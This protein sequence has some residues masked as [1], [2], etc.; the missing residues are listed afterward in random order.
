MLQT[1]V[2]YSTNL[3][4]ILDALKDAMRKPRFATTVKVCHN[5]VADWSDSRKQ[6]LS[7]LEGTP[8]LDSLLSLPFEHICQY[9]ELLKNIVDKTPSI[10]PDYV[11]VKQALQ[12]VSRAAQQART[13]KSDRQRCQ[14]FI[15]VA[16]SITGFPKVQGYLNNLCS[17]H[18]SCFSKNSNLINVAS[19][20]EVYYETK[21]NM[22]I[23]IYV[24]M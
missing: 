24:M 7:R 10:H 22:C 6:A 3:P 19:Y 18:L 4:Q 21:A 16:M 2:Q 13:A 9:R 1:L 20:I 14:D 5:C 8:Q 11:E 15:A 17:Y 23:V 12:L